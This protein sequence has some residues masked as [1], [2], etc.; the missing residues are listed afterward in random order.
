MIARVANLPKIRP[1]RVLPFT[2]VRK[3]KRRSKPDRPADGREVVAQ[4][5]GRGR[6][7]AQAERA[8]SRRRPPDAD[9][10]FV[11]ADGAFAADDQFNVP[12]SAGLCHQLLQA[13]GSVDKG[14]GN[15]CLL[16]RAV[17][18]NPMGVV[19]LQL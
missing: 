15:G 9:V 2:Y 1:S 10:N 13:R 5:H 6:A 3:K 8:K 12:G 14:S 4:H 19:S 16:R 18:N 11:I 7:A 17:R